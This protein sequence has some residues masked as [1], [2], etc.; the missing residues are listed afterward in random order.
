MWNII[1]AQKQKW[2]NIKRVTENNAGNFIIKL[3]IKNRGTRKSQ[4]SEWFIFG[5]DVNFWLNNKE[6][7]FSLATETEEDVKMLS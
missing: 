1:M 4:I 6:S 3:I 2:N 7:V 5:G